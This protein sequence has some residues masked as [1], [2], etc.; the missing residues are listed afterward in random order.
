MGGDRG[1]WWSIHLLGTSY[2]DTASIQPSSPICPPTT[3]DLPPKEVQELLVP[4]EGPVRTT[5]S[6][7]ESPAVALLPVRCLLSPPVA[8]G[9]GQGHQPLG[10]TRSSELHAPPLQQQESHFS[11]NRDPKAC[12][13]GV[14]QPLATEC[15][16]RP[17]CLHAPVAQVG[18]LVCKMRAFSK[19]RDASM[20]DPITV[21]L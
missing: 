11:R 3:E 5:G 8:S 9:T 2:G 6:S 12:L 17:T 18:S 13:P 10:R 20:Q 16:H 1:P 21:N 4:W 19:P 7:S 14:P 15:G